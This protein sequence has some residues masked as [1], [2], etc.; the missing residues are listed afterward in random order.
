MKTKNGEVKT[1]RVLFL[2]QAE[3]SI[4]V[5]VLDCFLERLRHAEKSG[6]VLL[7]QSI[8][9]LEVGWKPAIGVVSHFLKRRSTTCQVIVI[10]MSSSPIF[11]HNDGLTAYLIFSRWHSCSTHRVA[12]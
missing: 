2:Q 10:S 4:A 7:E 12:R 3:E 11:I 1:V 8:D 6:G 5:H 9:I